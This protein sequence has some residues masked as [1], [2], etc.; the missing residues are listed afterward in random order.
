ME[1]FFK[2]ILSLSANKKEAITV[3]VILLIPLKVDSVHI[4]ENQWLS[5]PNHHL[6]MASSSHLTSVE[7]LFPQH[8]DRN[9]AYL[10]HRSVVWFK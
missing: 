8:G 9:N 7:H 5:W 2:K 4:P 6:S 3:A 10:D 1:I